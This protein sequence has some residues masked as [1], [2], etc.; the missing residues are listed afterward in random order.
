M[1]EFLFADKGNGLPDKILIIAFHR[2]LQLKKPD[3]KGS[4]TWKQR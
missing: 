3:F 2:A 4:V 1:A